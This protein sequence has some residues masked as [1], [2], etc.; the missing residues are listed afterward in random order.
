MLVIYGSK[1]FIWG[2]SDTPKWNELG[3]LSLL[4]D[5]AYANTASASYTPAGSVTGAQF[6]GSQSSVTITATDNVSGNYQ[7]KGTVSI[8][9][10]EGANTT[11]TGSFTPSGE[12][13]LNN[14]TVTWGVSTASGT[15]SYQPK[16]S[17]TAPT[18]SLATAGATAQ[19][20]QIST[21]GKPVS[22]LLTA[23]PGATAPANAIT[24]YDV[25]T[26]TETLRLYQIG[27][28]TANA[29]STADGT[30]VKT[31]DA[32]Y[33]ASAPTFT[34]TAVRLVASGSN[35]T[36]ATFTGTA[37]TVETSGIP[38]IGSGAIA[39]FTGTKVQ[40]SGVTTAAGSVSSATFT[41]TPAT[42]TVSPD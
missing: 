6:T 41:G 42:I 27:A 18:I 28:S 29:I 39:T 32:S 11:F 8:S 24:Y 1:Q 20:Q 37:D 38:N 2:P 22:S 36:G 23:A 4:G 3:D 25:P 16:G 31:G 19:I 40:L 13:T 33:T 14:G 15:T 17:V 5:L 7:P 30:I 34:G 35:T 21:I 10:I 12:I 26:G 9:G